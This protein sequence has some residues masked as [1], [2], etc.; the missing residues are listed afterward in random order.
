M[1]RNSVF[2]LALGLAGVLS[3]SSLPVSAKGSD[4]STGTAKQNGIEM[5]LSTDQLSYTAG[6]EIN[7][8]LHVENTSDVLIKQLTLRNHK[9]SE[10]DLEDGSRTMGTLEELSPGAQAVLSTVFI[11]KGEG[12][13][14]DITPTVDPYDD[15]DVDLTL[16][17]GADGYEADIT[18]SPDDG[19]NTGTTGWDGT[20]GSYNFPTDSGS[21]Y[22]NDTAATPTPTRAP[23]E[24]DAFIAAYLTGTVAITPPAGQISLTPGVVQAAYAVK[25]KDE[26][27][28]EFWTGLFVCSFI[29]AI[30]V[31]VA[32]WKRRKGLLSL[33][34]IFSLL[35]SISLYQ[36]AGAEDTWDVVDVGEETDGVYDEAEGFE[37]D[38]NAVET[39]PFSTGGL[40]PDG[41]E[42]WE[43]HLSTI[44]L[45]D[46]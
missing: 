26:S 15:I 44:I 10:A 6:D 45:I 7:V 12:G 18:L 29:L 28:A 24:Y 32:G 21:G 19:T 22:V 30:F 1:K 25:T 3:L 13:G 23:T 27:S 38:D 31:S 39:D 9:P 17:P 43:L 41:Y 8:T 36:R 33:L 5:T 2:F 34:L 46:N 20:D 37:Y 42:E 14:H 16:T 11:A 40:A 4:G 35:G